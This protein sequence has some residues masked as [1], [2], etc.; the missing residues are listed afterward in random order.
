[1][2]ISKRTISAVALAVVAAI[3]SGGDT[4]VGPGGEVV[5]TGVIAQGTLDLS[6]VWERRI[7]ND[8]QVS[9]SSLGWEH[10][11]EPESGKSVALQLIPRKEGVSQ[12]LASGLKGHRRT[13][14]WTPGEVTKQ[15]Y[16]IRHSVIGGAPSEADL[17]AYFSFENCDQEAPSAADVHAAIRSDGGAD[18]KYGIAN[19]IGNWWT[20]TGAPGEG[21][22][23]P[24]GKSEFKITVEGSGCFRFDYTLAGGTW[25]VKVDGVIV[26]TLDA[27][28]D[29]TGAEF[30]VNGALAAHV[31]DFVTELSDGDSAALK[32]VRWAD[33]C[34]CFGGGQGRAGMVDLRTNDVLVVKRPNELMPFAWSSTNFTGVI[35]IGPGETQKIDPMSVVSVRIVQ[36]TGTGDDVS[37]WTAEA[38]DTA[39]AL[40]AE[41]KGEGTVKWKGVNPGV[42]K[43]ELVIVSPAGEVYRETRVLDLRKYSGQGLVFFL[44]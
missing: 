16:N 39:M 31:V 15:V 20:L 25:T 4:I 40:V 36:V 43:A 23:A 18:S 14:V 1:M 34:D 30:S 21:I 6:D 28:A 27:A 8:E 17:N 22:A 19:D 35:E 11:A 32:N 29:W 26:R 7:V 3:A 38:D 33:T 13:Y 42:W 12:T 41:Q 44:K 24:Q 10:V 9:W 2:D 37:Q 5:C